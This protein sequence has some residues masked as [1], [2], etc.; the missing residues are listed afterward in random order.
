MSDTTPDGGDGNGGPFLECT[1]T[2]PLYHV[3]QVTA[4]HIGADGVTMTF[5]APLPPSAGQ[6]PDPAMRAEL[7]L[8][9]GAADF[10]R[11]LRRLVE[12][13]A[14]MVDAGTLTAAPKEAYSKL[15]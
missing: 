5:G 4:F 3:A 7:H 10:E 8:H 11:L 14:R 9:L 6:R 13:R 15:S 2:A 1:A 12:I